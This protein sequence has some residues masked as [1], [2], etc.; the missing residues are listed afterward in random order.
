[1][2]SQEDCCLLLH[3]QPVRWIL[4]WIA[5]AHNTELFPLSTT[6]W[7]ALFLGGTGLK[8]FS[9]CSQLSVAEKS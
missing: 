7:K 5:S 9:S 2:V 6:S 4:H 3:S 1:M 8:Y